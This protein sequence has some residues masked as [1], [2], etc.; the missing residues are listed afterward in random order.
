MTAM[1][2]AALSA[3]RKQPAATT[4]LVNILFIL[5]SANIFHR[6]MTARVTS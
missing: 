3:A 5:V 6:T 1:A 2:A 4:R